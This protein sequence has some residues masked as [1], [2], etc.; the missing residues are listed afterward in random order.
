M[1][2]LPDLTIVAEQLAALA[3]GR[4]VREATAPAPILV[5]ATPQEPSR[6]RHFGCALSAWCRLV[7]P[8]IVIGDSPW[9]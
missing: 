1:P 2:E 8:V 3:T 9:P 4:T 7:R 5:R 6:S